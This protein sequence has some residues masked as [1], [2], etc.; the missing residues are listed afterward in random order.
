MGG[1]VLMFFP[2]RNRSCE[3]GGKEGAAE[4][5]R[6][7]RKGRQDEWKKCEGRTE[8]RKEMQIPRKMLYSE[9]DKN[10]R[11]H[12]RRH[13]HHMGQLLWGACVV[14]KAATCSGVPTCVMYVAAVWFSYSNNYVLF[15]V[16]T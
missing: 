10:R 3:Q 2:C 11:T 7:G 13:G 15:F 12:R 6:N 9:T 14:W 5:R 16:I 4:G 8:G 1:V